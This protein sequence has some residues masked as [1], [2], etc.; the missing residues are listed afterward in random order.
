MPAG[1]ECIFGKYLNSFTVQFVNFN[2]KVF[3]HLMLDTPAF[4]GEFLI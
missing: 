3:I 4:P 2:L 1:F